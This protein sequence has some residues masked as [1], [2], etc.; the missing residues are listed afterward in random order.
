MISAVNELK[1]KK[2]DEVRESD[3]IKTVNSILEYQ[4]GKE[5]GFSNQSKNQRFDDSMRLLAELTVGTPA[6][7]YYRAQLE[8][9]NAAR[10]LS[11]DSPGYLKPETFL[12]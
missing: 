3:L 12:Q 7:K 2:V 8:K 11:P 1:A 5:K 9:V 4:D 10:G 6:E